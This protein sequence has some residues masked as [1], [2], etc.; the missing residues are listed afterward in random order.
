MQKELEACRESMLR[1][2]LAYPEVAFLL[3]ST[4]PRR[5]LIHLSKAIFRF[6]MKS[7][8]SVMSHACCRLLDVMQGRNVTDV[9][10]LI[11]GQHC[12]SLSEAAYTTAALSV[13]GYLT[14][15]PASFGHKHKQ[16]LYINNRYVRAGQVGKLV[17]NL[18]RSAMVKLEQ[19]ED[20]QRKSSHQYPAFALQ[21]TCPPSS[22]DI[23]SD[24]DKAHVEF[25]D[26][27]A[28]MAAVQAAVL[29]AWHSVVG[30]NLLAELSQNQQA[31]AAMPAT[32]LT[33]SAGTVQPAPLSSD[34][35][36]QQLPLNQQ[37]LRHSSPAAVGKNCKRYQDSSC[38]TNPEQA[39]V[40]SLFGNPAAGAR[41]SHTFTALKSADNASDNITAVEDR[42]ASSAEA[43][44]PPEAAPRGFL[45]RLQSSAK[46]RVAQVTPQQ[47]QDKCHQLPERPMLGAG[48]ADA[49]L[50][51]ASLLDDEHEAD[52]AMPELFYEPGSHQLPATADEELISWLPQGLNK[53]ADSRHL[54]TQQQQRHQQ[55][56]SGQQRSKSLRPRKRRATSAPP[57]Y[58]SHRRSAHTNPLHS[59]C[60]GLQEAAQPSTAANTSRLQTGRSTSQASAAEEQGT[61]V[62][63]LDRQVRREQ[64]TISGVC[65][66][67]RQKLAGTGQVQLSDAFRQKRHGSL[68]QSAHRTALMPE[69]TMSGATACQ[70]QLQPTC[71]V[72]HG[73]SKTSKSHGLQLSKAGEPA[74][75]KRVRFERSLDDPPQTHG[76]TLNALPSAPTPG[77]PSTPIVTPSAAQ[78]AHQQTPV[79]FPAVTATPTDTQSAHAGSA[80]PKADALLAQQT[81]PAMPSITELLQSWSNPSIHPTAGRGIADIA[82][83]C[84]NALHTV[85]PSTIT[86][87]TFEQAQTLRQMENKF[88]AVVCNGVLCVIDQ[89]AA[90]ERVRLEKLRTAVLGSQVSDHVPGA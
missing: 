14:C 12:N 26:W 24:P 83:A 2:A 18:F 29:D 52:P 80:E 46:L 75:R 84:G 10:P 11:F 36:S 68:D 53:L 49:H 30:S 51:L 63:I 74:V 37:R 59:L 9:L 48:G 33:A 66:Q 43:S 61:H 44:L 71:A 90:D 47:P 42:P 64:H 73:P 69:G 55:K 34:A 23:T 17:S 67:L 88:I 27:P 25:A 31:T 20:Q 50:E 65:S 56:Q 41:H 70:A 57:H 22:Y 35:K 40:N 54:S 45:S 21:I 39:S 82:S 38:F 1:L 8:K 5:Q 81:S 7:I 79:T 77:N 4:K 89:H 3:S 19:P 32:I 13:Q 16:Y 87:G 86:R 76:F 78:L 28:V 85:V 62:W 72:E 15:P 60:T 58:R 6:A